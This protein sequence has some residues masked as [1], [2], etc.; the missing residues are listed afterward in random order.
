MGTKRSARKRS[1]GSQKEMSAE[2]RKGLAL[3]RDLSKDQST[4]ARQRLSSIALH[5]AR[6]SGPFLIADD[7]RV[8]TSIPHPAS[9]LVTA[10]VLLE[11]MFELRALRL[12]NFI[13]LAEE[14]L[15]RP[16][17]E[18]FTMMQKA[19]AKLKEERRANEAR[20][21][22]W[23]EHLRQWLNVEWQYF[24]ATWGWQSLGPTARDDLEWSDRMRSEAIRMMQARNP[25]SEERFAV[26]LRDLAR[27]A[28]RVRDADHVMWLDSWVDR[29]ALAVAGDQGARKKI[30]EQARQRVGKRH[31]PIRQAKQRY[32]AAAVT[33]WAAEPTLSIE[34]MIDTLPAP[35][36]PISRPVLR[37]WINSLCPD[38]RPGRR[39][40]RCK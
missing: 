25:V 36:V 7:G 13:E 18:R 27:H 33:A 28:L 29:W 19:P 2:E 23:R 22:P 12:S 37:R 6:G 20:W 26:E 16:V 34:D 8:A 17:N 24:E 5:I 35:D 14:K 40:K 15:E 38:R 3:L 31:E 30:S 32:R 1:S 39:A 9:S 10:E 11:R 21:L 4:E